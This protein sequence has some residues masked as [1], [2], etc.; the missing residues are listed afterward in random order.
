MLIPDKWKS[1]N[2]SVLQKQRRVSSRDSYDILRDQACPSPVL[3]NL[4][5]TRLHQKDEKGPPVIGAARQAP[6]TDI[7]ARIVRSPINVATNS[8]PD[9]ALSQT[10]MEDTIRS[11]T[12]PKPVPI[13]GI[14]RMLSSLASMPRR[15]RLNTNGNGPDVF[16]WDSPVWRMVHWSDE[17]SVAGSAT[18]AETGRH[19]G[20]GVLFIDHLP[21]RTG[22]RLW[23][24]G[25]DMILTPFSISPMTD[26]AVDCL[27]TLFLAYCTLADS[28]DVLSID[29]RV[30]P[31]PSDSD[32]VPLLTNCAFGLRPSFLSRSRR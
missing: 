13:M 29:D 19:M 10:I 31:Q 14:M 3:T 15:K 20:R 7:K 17:I 27:P 5:T 8:N 11:S 24:G 30:M 2:D 18:E 9:D 16:S 12:T 21:S 23:M 6:C 22:S 1:T 28:D 26:V 25:D 32:P 4:T